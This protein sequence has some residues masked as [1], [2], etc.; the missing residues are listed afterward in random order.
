VNVFVDTNIL[1]EIYHL[2]GPDL[3]ELLK[4]IK[5]AEN[6][7]ITVLITQQVH[8]EFWRNRERVVKEA[9]DLFAKTKA[10]ATLPNLVRGYP[11]TGE[12]R[13]VV[14]KV[15]ALVKELKA[16]ADKEAAENKLKAD[17]LIE[18]LFARC[19]PQPVDV[20]IY[21]KARFRRDIGNPPGKGG[22]MGD[23]AN[24]EWLKAAVGKG[25]SV[26]IV[27]A[28]GDFES[29]LVPGQ[30]KE[31]LSRE[32]ESDV[33]GKV[34]LYKSLPS[35]LAANFPEI[36]LANEIDKMLAIEA[37]EQSSSF[38]ATH[39]AIRNL[40]KFDDLTQQEVV[41]LLT[42]YVANSQIHWILGDDDVGAFAKKLVGLA[43]S[44]EAKPLA[45]R[46]QAMLN[47]LDA[48]DVDLDDDGDI[49]F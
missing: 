31:F 36:K 28:D 43:K 32:W 44:A 37:L 49:P 15:N 29:E 9:L 14:D 2:S 48:P 45:E 20:Q 24:W 46:L 33:G 34:V 47:Q 38:T 7:K 5:L 30:V 39:R 10:S 18:Q 11:K 21:N 1:L 40:S 6:G 26:A 16:A 13:E 27:S 3:D 19:P 12:L 4:V 25:G 22:S 8:D 17:L 35:F 23:A 42:A 41:R